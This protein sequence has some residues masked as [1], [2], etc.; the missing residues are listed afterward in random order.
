LAALFADAFFKM[1][2]E[3]LTGHAPRTLYLGCRFNTAPVEVV[4][5]LAEYAD[6]ISINDYSYRPNLGL[7]RAVDKPVLLTEFHF[8]NISGNNLGGGLRSA[9]DGVQ[10]GRLFRSF[11]EAA[12]THPRIVGTHWFQWNDQNV[13]GRH[14]GENYNV[15]F[16][17]VADKPNG[18]LVRA[19]EAS[20]RAL[21]QRRLAP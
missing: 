13:T 12:A 20:G 2:K 16:F 21:Y 14:D 4:T 15:G 5:K 10:M 18:E 1:V 8:A 3:E 9:A 7:A 11:V 17:D 19:A 6:A